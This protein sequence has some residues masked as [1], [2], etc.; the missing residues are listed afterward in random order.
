MTGDAQGLLAV[1]TSIADGEDIN[2]IQV[3]A[4]LAS[5]RERELL[6]SLRIIA[7]IGELHRSTDADPADDPSERRG[8]V[9][10]R[11]GPIGAPGTPDARPVAP[12][13]DG[14]DATGLDLSAARASAAANAASAAATPA[15]SSSSSASPALPERWGTLTIRQ[16]VGAGVFGDVYRA[17]DEQLQRE[18][19][20]KLLRTGTRSADRLVG[21]VLHEGR[22]LARVRHPNVVVVHGVE[23]RGDRVGLWMEFIRGATLEQLLERQGLFGAREAAL[24]GQDLCRALAAVHAAGLVHRD[25]KAQNVMREEGGR[26][27]LMDFGTGIPIDDD[28]HASPAAGTP[29]YLAPELLEGEEATPASDLYS[30]GVLLYHLVTG[31][32]PITAS[33]LVELRKAH[34]RGRTRLQDARPDLPDAFVQAVDRALAPDPADRP[35]SA[36]AM[37]DAL[38]RALGIDVVTTPSVAGVPAAEPAAA[39]LDA[40]APATLLSTGAATPTAPS[41]STLPTAIPSTVDSPSIATHVSR[42]VAVRTWILGVGLIAIAVAIIFWVVP[43]W[44]TPAPGPINS[45]VVLPLA[46]ISSADRDLAEGIN[47][48]IV[49][50]LSMLPTLRVVQ[51]TPSMASRDKG[52]A[53]SEIIQRAQTDGAISGSVDWTGARAHVYLQLVRAGTNTPLWMKQFDVPARRAGELPRSVAREVAS[54]LSVKLT[55]SDDLALAGRE[56]SEPEAFENYLRARVNMRTGSVPAVKQAIEQLQEAIRLDPSHAPSL[57]ALA[58]CYI[59]Q[60]VSQRTRGFDEAATLARDAAEK[61]LRLDNQ[62]PEAYQALAEVRFYMD[63]DWAGAERDYKRAI[64]FRP[65]SG[66]LRSRYAMFLAS[67]KRLPDAMQEV[68][69]AVALDPMSPLANASLGLLWHYARSD[70]QAERIYRG[71]LESDPAYM[72]ARLGLIRTY[73]RTRRYEQAVKELERNRDDARGELSVGQQ[74]MLA[75]AYAGLGRTIEAQQIAEHI[76]KI[77]GSQPSVDAAGVFVALNERARALDILERAVALKSP[78]VLFLRLDLR[79]DALLTDPRF[80]SLLRRMGFAS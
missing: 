25:V 79:F 59:M 4:G 63:W 64:E 65:N 60:A 75:V 24:I 43:F 30:L 19:A 39:P 80:Q 31:S 45:I 17:Y 20:L 73:L 41:T 47:V 22:L 15:S 16:H 21:K 32:Y 42:R 13:G 44:R 76:E 23:A 72:P 57:A 7:E 50:Q 55:A 27:V 26:V 56:G 37:Q 62:L 36:G 53:V 70:D 48:L 58:Q 38:T 66:D 49:E 34:R 78:R 46:N 8:R 33:S 77:E 14:L 2:W 6:R 9:V 29:L 52:V 51:Y 18:V 28:S 40:A 11:I 54:A 12:P 1:A 35:A 10:G 61:A 69:Q 67:R 3:E 68:H 74:S 71:V 5:E